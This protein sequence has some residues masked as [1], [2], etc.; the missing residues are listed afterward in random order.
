MG[1]P[2]GSLW[3]LGLSSEAFRS[4]SPTSKDTPLSFHHLP[5]RCRRWCLHEA[6]GA[7]RCLQR[8]GPTSV[9]QII[10][11]KFNIFQ[12]FSLVLGPI[13]QPPNPPRCEV[14]GYHFEITG[15]LHLAQRCSEL[16]TQNTQIDC[17][18]LPNVLQG[19]WD[20]DKR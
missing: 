20:M 19:Q 18:D 13:L 2:F 1:W 16:P 10:T 15:S 4:V 3:C 8:I 9:Y 6:F 11:Q 7:H 17:L 5:P 14:P 12:H